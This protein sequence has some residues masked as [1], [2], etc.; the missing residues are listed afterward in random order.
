MKKII[1][2]PIVAMAILGGCDSDSKADEASKENQAQLI[3]GRLIDSYIFGADYKCGNKD[4]KETDKNGKFSCREFPISFSIGGVKLGKI[5]KLPNDKLV[6]PQDLAG[7]SRVDLNNSKVIAIAK[8]LQSLDRDNN[9]EDGIEIVKEYKDK[10]NDKIYE[11]DDI[12]SA[13]SI[14]Q[15]LSQKVS[16][17]KIVDIQRAKSHLKDTTEIFEEVAKLPKPTRDD[18]SVVAPQIDNNLKKAIANIEAD[19]SMALDIY[20]HIQEQLGSN[21]KEFKDVSE[22]IFK[23]GLFPIKTITFK[24]S[25]LKDYIKDI[26][27]EQKSYVDEKKAEGENSLTDALKVG[28]KVEV[29]KVNDANSAIN[30]IQATSYPDIFKIV[31]IERTN[32][33]AN[34]NEFNNKL[35]K[36]G[37]ANGCCSLGSE[38]CLTGANVTFDDNKTVIEDETKPEVKDNNSSENNSSNWK[39]KDSDEDSDS[40][41]DYDDSNSSSVELG[42]TKKDSSVSTED[43]EEKDSKTSNNTT[44]DESNTKYK[45]DEK[46]SSDNKDKGTQKDSNIEK[47]PSTKDDKS[48]N[49]QSNWKQ[50]DSNEDPKYTNDYDDSTK[51]SVELNSK[52]ANSSETNYSKKDEDNNEKTKSGNTQYGEETGIGYYYTHKDS[53]SSDKTTKDDEDIE[54]TAKSE[55]E[56]TSKDTNKTSNWV[57]KNS[58]EDPY[59]TNDYDK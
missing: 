7:V 10:L 2:L 16:G 31:N 53:N 58:D 28:C 56:P 19:K 8:F 32:A 30:L 29:K 44:S 6:F 48:K 13:D 18:Y 34:Y 42:N 49:S 54:K 15:D 22:I 5:D 45:T 37:V 35:I 46:D 11:I 55:K 12:A 47:V 39:Q 51:D 14:L 3:E 57:E 27:K 26:I 9:P 38:Y 43:K 23:R 52:S 59:D 21:A 41:N 24:Y 33:L 20:L 1:I 4:K 36:E 25:I 17:I 40:T 50:K